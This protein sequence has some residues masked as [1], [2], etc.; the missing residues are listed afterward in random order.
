MKQEYQKFIAKMD[1]LR[2]N[3][4]VCVPEKV[5]AFFGKSRFIP[6]EGLTNRG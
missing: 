6:V 1:T 3:P 4:W 2:V 5:S